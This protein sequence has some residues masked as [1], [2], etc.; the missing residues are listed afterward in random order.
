MRAGISQTARSAPRADSI[1]IFSYVSTATARLG[2]DLACLSGVCGYV[3]TVSPITREA[4]NKKIF[5]IFAINGAE[6]MI[7][8]WI[9]YPPRQKCFVCVE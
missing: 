2:D 5:F 8:Y 6:W 9:T 7:V 4:S 1:N 3:F